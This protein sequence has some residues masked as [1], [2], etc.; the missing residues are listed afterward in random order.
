[1]ASGGESEAKEQ[2]IDMVAGDCVVINNK[3]QYPTQYASTICI[4]T[5]LYILL[6]QIHPHMTQD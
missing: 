5:L 6:T 3:L 4:G 2:C 1:V